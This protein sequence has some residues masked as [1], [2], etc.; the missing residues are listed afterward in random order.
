MYFYLFLLAFCFS[1]VLICF[2]VA[3]YVVIIIIINNSVALSDI[4]PIVGGVILFYIV[5]VHLY[6]ML[7]TITFTIS[8]NSHHD[9]I[10][11]M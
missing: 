1:F 9:I 5:T 2:S 8:I 7:Y 3:T 11:V 4:I 10:F 6:L